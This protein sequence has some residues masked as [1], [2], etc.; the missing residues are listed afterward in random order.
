MANR[1]RLIRK[2]KRYTQTYI[3]SIVN[4]GQST[5]S[6]WEAGKV[7]IDDAS[8][9]KLSDFYYVSSDFLMGVP[10]TITRPV[11]EWE[12]SLREDYYKGNEDLRTYMEYRYGKP[13]FHN[14]IKKEPTYDGGLENAIILCRNGR[15]KAVHLTEDQLDYFE[16]L[17]DS[18]QKK[19][20]SE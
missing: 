5:Y 12:E 2:V 3:A 13:V 16:A 6:L 9:S 1:L 11:S 4:I 8:I 20:Q 15:N 14:T 10:F 18:C 19:N 7:R 17:L